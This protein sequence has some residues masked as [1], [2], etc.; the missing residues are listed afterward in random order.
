MPVCSLKPQGR[1]CNNIY[2][3]NFEEFIGHIRRISPKSGDSV[4]SFYIEE[5]GRFDTDAL[6][7]LKHLV[8]HVKNKVEDTPTPQV[9]EELQLPNHTI[10]GVT[11]YFTNSG[12]KSRNTRKFSIDGKAASKREK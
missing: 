2:S 11:Y 5:N 1:L 10:T 6:D 8:T 3:E 9:P 4:N 12:A 7:F